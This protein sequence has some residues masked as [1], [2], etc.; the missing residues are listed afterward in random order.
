MLR[1][2]LTVLA[3]AASIAAIATPAAAEPVHQL[4]IYQL[5][6]HTRAAFLDRFRDHAQRIMARHG[7]DIVAMWESEH[8]GSPEFVYLLRWPDAEAKDARWKAFSEDEEWIR[9]KAET[10]AED[11]PPLV[12][13]EDRMLDRVS[14]SPVFE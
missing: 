6:T 7:F 12:A 14:F 1:Y 3:A 2:R 5:D 8:N 10:P 11:R 13:I 4:R 9:I